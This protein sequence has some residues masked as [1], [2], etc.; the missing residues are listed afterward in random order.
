MR[1]VSQQQEQWSSKLG[2]VFATA[3]TAIGLGAIWKFPYIA[4][5]SGGGAFFLLF[6]LFT[7]LIGLPLLI[8]E[9]VLGRTTGKEA[10]S[11][12]K[13]LAPKSFW[14]IT[15]WIGVVAC[16][17]ILS[18]YSVI[19]GWSLLYILETLTGQMNNLTVEQLS[20][21]FGEMIASPWR[22]L[23][24]QALFMLMTIYVISKGVQSGIE[25]A[26][27]IMMPALLILLVII[28]ARSLT[29]EGAWE[30]VQFLLKPQWSN[31]QSDTILF[32]LGQAFF[33]LSLGV[34]VMVTYSSYVSKKQNLPLTATIIGVMNII[35]ALLAGL[36]I[37]PG[38]F[39][40]GLEPSE[41]PALIFVVLP[42][43]FNQMPLGTLFML[44]FF[45]LF[46]FAALTSAFSLLEIIVATFSKG[47]QQKRVKFS[48]GIGTIIFIVGIPSALSYGVLADFQL[49]NLTFF[50][51]LDYLASNILL[52]VGA[53]LVALFITRKV[54]KERLL[55]EIKQGSN[56]GMRFFACWYFL[57]K[58]MIPLAIIIIF[59][60]VLG[61]FQL[62][63]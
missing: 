2:F 36:M 27:K 61:V 52:P 13:E 37:F 63:F 34:S 9:F 47:D 10:V 20:N 32:A 35:V 51:S 48:W 33:A 41:G 53:L 12:Y 24:A 4:G 55:N 15:G 49:F 45:I 5:T 22:A 54:P 31:I 58:Y 59:L 19:G 30:G 3:G 44:A 17:L 8:G 57:V 29:L 21:K 42:T 40:F 23:G 50:D 1:S 7:F 14:P 16:F 25:R 43:I 39:T 60:D 62:F 11:T 26:S 56:V 18:F 46:F 28:A 38:V 6:L